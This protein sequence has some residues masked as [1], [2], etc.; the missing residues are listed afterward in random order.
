MAEFGRL[1]ILVNNAAEQ[2]PQ[3][4]ITQISPEQLEQTF[5]TNI[6]SFF[7]MTQAALPAGRVDAQ[8]RRLC[9]V[10]PAHEP[11]FAVRLV[12]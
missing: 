3:D 7:Y 11:T 9:E 1:D 5:R 4:C 8:G 10:C 2:Q 12:A 6:F